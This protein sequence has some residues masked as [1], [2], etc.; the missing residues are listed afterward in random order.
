VT[1]FKIGS[2]E[3]LQAWFLKN[4]INIKQNYYKEYRIHRFESQK[5][6]DIQKKMR[7]AMG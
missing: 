3:C 7:Q 2:T 5:N 6:I 4:K 1:F